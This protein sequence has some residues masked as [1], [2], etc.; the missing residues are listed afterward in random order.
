MR[1]EIKTKR[2]RISEYGFACG[3]VESKYY[4]RVNICLWMEHNVYHVRAHNHENKR[5]IFW[6]SFILLSEARKHYDHGEALIVA[7][8]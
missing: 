3:Y 5:R 8:E 2:G 1:N 7:H 6:H 4:G